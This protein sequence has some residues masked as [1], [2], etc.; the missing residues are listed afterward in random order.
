LKDE[1]ME[2][3]E[4]QLKRCQEQL[5]ERDAQLQHVRKE[6]SCAL[7]ARACADEVHGTRVVK[8]AATPLVEAAYHGLGAH[9]INT[10]LN[11]PTLVMILFRCR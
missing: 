2:D 4:R 9:G 8:A 5:A 10:F 3:L 7:K 1:K 11:T 6:L